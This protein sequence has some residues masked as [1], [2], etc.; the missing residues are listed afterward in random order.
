MPN[1]NILVVI[2]V[3]NHLDQLR[4][5]AQ[6]ALQ[7]HPDVLVVDD[8]SDED[9][10][11]ALKDLNVK[12]IRHEKNLGKGRAIQTGIDHAAKMGKTHIITI[13]ADGQ[14]PPDRIPDFIKA[15]EKNPAAII[16][17]VRDFDSSDNVPGSSKFGRAFGN[18]WV[19]LQTGHRVGDIQSGFR[20]YPVAIFQH[21]KFMFDTFAFEDEVVVRAAWADVPIDQIDIE[22]FYPP[23]NQRI[24]HFRKLRDNLNLTVLNTYLTIRSALPW[25]HKKIVHENG[26]TRA[27]SNP[28]KIIK[29]ALTSKSTPFK[30]GLAAALGVLMGTLPLIAIHIVAIMY[31]ASHLRLNKAIAICTSHICM[32]PLVPAICIETGHLI[33]HGRFLTLKDFS[34]LSDASFLQ[35]GSMG[36]QMIWQ[37]LLGS[38]LI[39]PVLAIIAGVIVYII[40]HAI[41]KTL[42]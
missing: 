7:V 34:S 42:T 19:R 41:R 30:L 2:P 23:A 36:A 27:V 32:P 3:Y 18:F 24:S 13:D 22:V 39:G 21:L 8:G 33:Q 10:A 31:V 40:S 38:L 1:I 15:I 37:W 20:A 11:V 28:V 16:I 26:K 6:G 9:V 17:G 29:E 5:V 12:I 35:V 25:P 4:N 14:H